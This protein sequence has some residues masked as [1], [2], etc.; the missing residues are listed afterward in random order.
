M[1]M[2]WELKNT[3]TVFYGPN[4]PGDGWVYSGDVSVLHGN[5]SRG[6][7]ET[8]KVW[9]KAAEP[10]PAKPAAPAPTSGSGLPAPNDGNYD[11]ILTNLGAQAQQGQ[12]QADTIKNQ[13]PTTD[14]AN[15][16]MKSITDLM[17]KQQQQQA[18]QLA[19][20]RVEADNQRNYLNNL[21]VQQQQAFAQQQ[22]LQQQQLA[23]AQSAY[24]E[25]RRQSEALS[26]AFV[27]SLQPTA[28][29]P[30][31]GD[32]RA[33]TGG[34]GTRSNNTLSSLSILSGVGLSGMTANPVIA[35][36]QIA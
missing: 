11:N 34:T 6:W 13:Q 1:A 8:V 19:A 2:P 10:A 3:D 22:A 30:A 32:S 29:A 25:Q 35:G 28:A 21:M 33:D 7:R 27:P 5:D 31:A 17:V 15:E 20:A 12:T 24:E 23:S 16:W 4:R 9:T 14:P 18:E 26:R 36:L